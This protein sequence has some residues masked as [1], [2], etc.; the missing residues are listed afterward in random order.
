MA[1]KKQGGD[2]GYHAFAWQVSD[3]IH[4]SIAVS[5]LESTVIDSA[6]FQRLRKI[7]QL[8]NVHLIFPG[9]IHNRFA[10]SL[11]AMHIAGKMFDALFRSVTADAVQDKSALDRRELRIIV[12]LAG[13]LHDVGH[14]PF[15][16]TFESCLKCKR[17]GQLSRC[18][19]NDLDESLR[20]PINWVDKQLRSKFF[21]SPLAHEHYSFGLIRHIFSKIDSPGDI[22][23]DVCSLL[24]E[25]ILPSARA[26]RLLEN[27]AGKV[28]NSTDTSSLRRCI[29]AILS[30]ELDADRLDYLQRDSFY[31]GVSIASIDSE[32]I[33]DSMSLSVRNKSDQ[34]KGENREIYI[35]INKSAIPAF[36]QVLISRKQMYDRVYHHRVNSGFDFIIEY[37]VDYLMEENPSKI[38]FP[39]SI[40]DF[41]MMTD[42]WLESH[43]MRLA[44][45][46]ERIP[47]N[48][49]LAAQL[50][51]TRTPLKKLAEED[52]EEV[53]VENRKSELQQLNNKGKSSDKKVV[54]AKKLSKLTNMPREGG[55]G[56]AHL[57]M[58]K[59]DS[60]DEKP[61][62]I[63]DVSHV[64]GS[65]AWREI[66]SRIFVFESFSK[67][68]QLRNLSNRL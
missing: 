27:I 6:P 23:Q 18:I 48:V 16:H 29:K 47:A 11:G 15:S 32:Y 12:R 36:E 20:I 10:H 46:K 62:A 4:G 34:S 40:E 7:K 5:N 58:V 43:I 8:G 22:A 14:G 66:M 64:L 68:A 56:E 42:D 25:R 13:L 31:C 3:P 37:L 1:S 45:S 33:L 63:S 19:V 28:F 24:D 60:E 53:K 61:K 21:D 30:G 26:T 2:H 35:S 54:F 57:I 51:V 17:D 50:F 55:T 39:K 67:T 44:K 65:T 52:V 41:L 59:P 38:N 9:A 49:K